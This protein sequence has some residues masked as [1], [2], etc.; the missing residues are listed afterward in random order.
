MSLADCR[1]ALEA[2]CRGRETLDPIEEWNEDFRSPIH[3]S[4]DV[5]SSTLGILW[6]HSAKFF[7]LKSISRGI[8]RREWNISFEHLHAYRFTF[9]PQADVLAIIEQGALM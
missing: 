9:Y 6:E 8:P 3:I 4:V 2:Y 1:V 5:V 7:A